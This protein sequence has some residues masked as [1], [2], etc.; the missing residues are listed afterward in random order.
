MKHISSRNTFFRKKKREIS[1]FAKTFANSFEFYRN[2]L[3]ESPA[4]GYLGAFLIFLTIY[5]VVFSPYFKIS[6]NNV[7]IEADSPG[8]DVNIAY[9][10]L[11][12]IY[13]KS[14]FL[15]NEEVVAL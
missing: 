8:I 1:H 10:T 3:K 12:D 6:P 13:G 7:L 14:I 2:H 9:R 5:I 4:L 11:E 15:V